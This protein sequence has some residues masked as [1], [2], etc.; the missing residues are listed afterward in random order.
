MKLI[1]TNGCFD[2]LHRGHV[3]LFKY[4]KS[5]GDFL[6]VGIDGDTR[7]RESKGPSRPINSQDDRKFFL[8]SIKYI[9]QVVVFDTSF[10]L[11][12]MI[13]MYKPEGL[14]VGSEYR[15]KGVVGGKY[16][17]KIHFFDRIG[18]YSTT[19]ILKSRGEK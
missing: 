17:K 15:T 11:E 7:I 14:V 10:Q 1:W 3:E 13:K 2:V 12:S 5:L 6:I 8:E 4:A 18:N 9:D 19:N 16:A